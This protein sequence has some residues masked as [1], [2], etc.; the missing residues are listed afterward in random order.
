M[1]LPHSMNKIATFLALALLLVCQFTMGERAAAN[2][3][4]KKI[5]S[6]QETVR[7]ALVYASSKQGGHPNSAD[8]IFQVKDL[9]YQI[10]YQLDEIDRIY[11]K[12][13]ELESHFKNYIK[14]LKIFRDELSLMPKFASEL[15]NDE[16]FKSK[17][18]NKRES[19]FH[20][21]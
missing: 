1:P 16:A 11:K 13:E 14:S 2:G 10:Q 9:Y 21:L 5:P 12:E 3:V 4:E 7:L 18:N 6:M 17:A 8:I 19:E 20:I 15:L